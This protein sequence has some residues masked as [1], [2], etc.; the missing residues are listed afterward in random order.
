MRRRMGELGLARFV[1]PVKPRQAGSR[2]GEQNRGVK[3][4]STTD[5]LRLLHGTVTTTG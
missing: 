5:F 1:Y 4:K 3:V 2:A